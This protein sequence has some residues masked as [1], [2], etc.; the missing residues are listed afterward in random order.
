MSQIL[1]L[2]STPAV[3]MRWPIVDGSTAIALTG[4]ECARSLT[5]G[6]E[7]EGD[8]SVTVPA[9]VGSFSSAPQS[10][11]RKRGLRNAPFWWPRWIKALCLFW[12]MVS[13]EPSFVRCSATSCPVEV[14]WYLRKPGLP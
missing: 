5:W 4:D 13:H 8:H 1:T 6:V 14:S 7:T 2:P 12:H 11:L 3:A 9:V 10:I